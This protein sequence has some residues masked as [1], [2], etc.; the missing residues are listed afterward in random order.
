MYASIRRYK[1][2]SV[3]EA[4]R[5][6]RRHFAH[7][8]RQA[9]GLVAYYIVESTEGEWTTVSIFEDR[10]AAER[11]DRLAADYIRREG[12]ADLMGEPEVT[13]GE[14]TLQLP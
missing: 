5:N 8:I 13:R 6:S 4:T 14:V 1:T 10:Q 7:A 12:V 2:E 9:P 11:S 3:S